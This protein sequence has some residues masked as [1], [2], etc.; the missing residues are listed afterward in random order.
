M[1]LDGTGLQIVSASAELF[2]IN[3]LVGLV[4]IPLRREDIRPK[5]REPD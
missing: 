5:H 4:L 2:Q 1:R 3:D